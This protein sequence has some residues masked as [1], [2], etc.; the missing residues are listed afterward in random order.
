MK[1][2]AR[3]LL[4]LGIFFISSNSLFAETISVTLYQHVNFNGGIAGSSEMISSDD[5]DLRDNQIGND[6][7]SSLNVPLGCLVVLYQHVDYRGTSEIFTSGD[8]DLRDNPIGNDTVSSVKVTCGLQGVKGDTGVSGAD[9][10]DGADGNDGTNGND[11]ATGDTGATG[12]GFFDWFSETIGDFDG[13]GAI[14][15]DDV[16][17]WLGNNPT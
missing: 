4:I 6:A 5:S 11:G 13:S 9:G 7:I 10:K 1:K 15:Q 12:Q 2:Y 8:F 16:Q 14:D 3:N 17:A